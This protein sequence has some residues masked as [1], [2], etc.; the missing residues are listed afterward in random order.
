[1]RGVLLRQGGGSAG[2]GLVPAFTVH[3]ELGM[4][5]QI[6]F[7]LLHLCTVTGA[8]ASQQ[9]VSSVAGMLVWGTTYSLPLLQPA[10]VRLRLLVWQQQHCWVKSVSAELCHAP[11]VSALFVCKKGPKTPDLQTSL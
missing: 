8:A 9:G 11:V 4:Q 5:H 10:L 7:G 2:A 6:A 1:M 3:H